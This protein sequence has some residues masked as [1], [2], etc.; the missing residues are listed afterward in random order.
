ML[1]LLLIGSD[2]RFPDNILGF[3]PINGVFPVQHIQRRV[4]QIFSLTSV[5]PLDI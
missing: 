2:I 5:Q 3:S 1:I 4:F